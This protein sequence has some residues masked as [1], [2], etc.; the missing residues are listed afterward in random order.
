MSGWISVFFLSRAI[1]GI[2]AAAGAPPLLAHI[3]DATERD[4][5]LRPRVMSYFELSLLAW[6]AFGSLVGAQLSHVSHTSASVTVVLLYLL[7]AGL[8]YFGVAGSRGH[9]VMKR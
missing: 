3:T 2:R 6:L 8:L 7:C 4:P 1:Q 5:A 9:A